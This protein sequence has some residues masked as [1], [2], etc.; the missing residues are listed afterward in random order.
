MQTGHFYF[1][2]RVQSSKHRREPLNHESRAANQQPSP[3][4]K[5]FGKTTLR[6]S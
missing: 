3:G 1:G 2:F 4:R 6:T 5:R